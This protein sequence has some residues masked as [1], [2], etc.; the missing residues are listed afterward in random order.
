MKEIQL[1][2]GQVALVD[3]EDYEELAKYKWQATWN[4]ASRTYY[5]RRNWWAGGGS[6]GTTKMHRAIMGAGDKEEVD[7]INHN[8]LD[9]RRENLRVC[10]KQQNQRNR[11]KSAGH[12]SRFKGV[13]FSKGKMRWQAYVCVPSAVGKGRHRHLG[14]FAAETDAAAAYDRAARELFG[15]FACLNGVADGGA[16]RRVVCVKLTDSDVGDIR[17]ALATLPVTQRALARAYGVS[18]TLISAVAR[19][20][21][22]PDL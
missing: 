18:Q 1:T 21:V 4:K 9:N 16:G 3:D 2:Q 19:G 10:T 20:K 17:C 13:S 6:W 14:Y 11:R 22:R 8:G 5:A 7:H 15:E 12:S